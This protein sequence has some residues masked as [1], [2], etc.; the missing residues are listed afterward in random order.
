MSRRASSQEVIN[1][2]ERTSSSN[3]SWNVNNAVN[4]LL[5]L[6]DA[7]GRKLY[8]T[9]TITL[10]TMLNI[11]FTSSLN[12][13]DTKMIERYIYMKNRYLIQNI[14]LVV[15]QLNQLKYVLLLQCIARINW[16]TKWNPGMCQILPP[17]CFAPTS[18]MHRLVMAEEQL[19]M[20]C[21]CK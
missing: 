13:C 15:L 4:C 6:N 3:P 21:M 11:K 16:N 10:Q 9:H 17:L 1:F 19:N 5:N 8:S 7:Q 2:W 18:C 12:V 14:L 20:L